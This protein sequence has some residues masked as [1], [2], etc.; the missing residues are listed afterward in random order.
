MSQTLTPEDVAA[1]P[2]APAGAEVVGLP[3]LLTPDDVAEVLQVSV[4]W[5]LNAARDGE[6]PC[7]RV[8]R[9]PRF[10]PADLRAFIE[11]A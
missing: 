1:S 11:Q 7:V 4:R 9:F 10:R 6:L 5:V 8:G 3:R 2:G